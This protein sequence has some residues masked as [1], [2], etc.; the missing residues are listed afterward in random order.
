ML[1]SLVLS[2][3]A[4]NEWIQLLAT[5]YG[6]DDTRSNFPFHLRLQCFRIQG[7]GKKLVRLSHSSVLFIHELAYWN[8]SMDLVLENTFL[9]DKS[10]ANL[11][12]GNLREKT[13]I[14]ETTALS[15]NI[16][17]NKNTENYARIGI[18]GVNP[19]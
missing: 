3:S 7:S 9:Q 18:H 8:P 12:I 10:D 1:Q 5:T 2:G 4:I 13:E 14:L 6:D 19:F 11:T 15:I 16:S 17:Y